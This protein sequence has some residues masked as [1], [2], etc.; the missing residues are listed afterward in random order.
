MLSKA[1]QTFHSA[2]KSLNHASKRG[3]CNVY[4]E[5]TNFIEQPKVHSPHSPTF[6]YF[7]VMCFGAW[8]S[9]TSEESTLLAKQIIATCE[10][11]LSVCNNLELQRRTLLGE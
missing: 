8:Q 2:Q 7:D 3:L 11:S 10:S 9:L 4:A 5:M 1:L 6:M